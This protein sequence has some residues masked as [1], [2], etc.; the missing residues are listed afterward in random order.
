MDEVIQINSTDY[1]IKTSF[2]DLIK[3]EQRELDCINK[4]IPVNSLINCICDGKIEIGRNS[5]NV[6]IINKTNE[7]WFFVHSVYQQYR[8]CDQL[9]GLVECLRK[10][11]NLTTNL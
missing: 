2:D 8:K 4:T 11:Y 3:F 10:I 9:Y 7:G 1:R 5:A 6:V